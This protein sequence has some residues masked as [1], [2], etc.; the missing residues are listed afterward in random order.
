MGERRAILIHIAQIADPQLLIWIC[1]GRYNPGLY[2]LLLVAHVAWWEPYSLHDL[3]GA[4]FL[5]WT[6]T[7][8]F[9]RNMS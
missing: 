9:L 7:I 5:R 3:R 1:Q 8:Q 2:D 6:C 4:C